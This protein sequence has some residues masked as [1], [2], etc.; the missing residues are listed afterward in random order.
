MERRGVGRY[1][2]IIANR[3]GRRRARTEFAMQLYRLALNLSCVSLFII[4]AATAQTPRAAVADVDRQ[5]REMLGDAVR[6]ADDIPDLD[7]RA[8]ALANC[9][10]RY[11][12][13]ADAG[14]SAKCFEKA[15]RAVHG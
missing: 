7:G 3:A 4:S 8:H 9:G 6:A 15:H 11:A 12:L 10:T 14:E 5:T 1:N 13:L 2:A